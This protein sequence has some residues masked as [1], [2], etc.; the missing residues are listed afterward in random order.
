M[1]EV[2]VLEDNVSTRKDI[3]MKIKKTHKSVRIH[4]MGDTEEAYRCAIKRN[5]CSFFLDVEVPGMNGIELAKKIRK[6]QRYEF[7]PIVFITGMPSK[8]LEAFRQAHAYEYILKPY[9]ENKIESTME[10]V[11]RNC[12]QDNKN[13]KLKKIAIT[14]NGVTQ[15]VALGDIKY[16][17][18]EKKKLRI[19]STNGVISPIRMPLKGLRELLDEEFQQVHQSIIVNMRYVEACNLVKRT[20]YIKDEKIPLPIGRTFKTAVEERI[21]EVQ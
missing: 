13:E 2:L 15:K 5:I 12:S 9:T 14:A 17:E 1:L 20:M 3:V 16:I 10:K 21:N 11:L 8:E 7:T 4:E 19:V 18:N 6:E